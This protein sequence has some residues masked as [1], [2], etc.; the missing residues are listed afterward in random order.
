MTRIDW[1][2][3]RAQ[4]QS[5]GSFA[6][7]RT[8]RIAGE[9]SSVLMPREVPSRIGGAGWP[10]DVFPASNILCP[11]GL[12]QGLLSQQNSS[13]WTL[14]PFGGGHHGR[15]ADLGRWINEVC[16]I[17]IRWNSKSWSS[18]GFKMPQNLSASLR[19]CERSLGPRVPLLL[20]AEVRRTQVF[21][22]LAGV[23]GGIARQWLTRPSDF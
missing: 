3:L 22:Q 10:F 8:G 23:G 18:Q 12:L 6:I 7:G 21:R 17:R 9:T 16:W 13:N 14:L 1:M 15:S 5:L 2:Y 19:G 4:T 20:L 11:I